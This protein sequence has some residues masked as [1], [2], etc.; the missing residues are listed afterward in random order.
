[1][2]TPAVERHQ[3][4]TSVLACVM[5]RRRATTQKVALDVV[6]ATLFD[7]AFVFWRAWSCTAR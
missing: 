5:R 2:R 4:S 1:M 6:D 3:A 7:F